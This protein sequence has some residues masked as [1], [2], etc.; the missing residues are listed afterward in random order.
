MMVHVDTSAAATRQELIESIPR[1]KDRVV[2]DPPHSTYGVGVSMTA[3][4]LI[5]RL[6]VLAIAGLLPEAHLPA[7]ATL[8]DRVGAIE[9]YGR[10]HSMVCLGQPRRL[11]TPT[12]IVALKRLTKGR[13]ALVH[14]QDDEDLTTTMGRLRPADV[15]E[16]L[17]VAEA[18]ARLPLFHELV[19]LEAK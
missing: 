13:N 9:R 10:K 7:R 12:D 6:L 5:E 8:G 18:V 19:C 4:R 17:E 3:T 15:V 11:V 1:W 14:L 16:M 2:S